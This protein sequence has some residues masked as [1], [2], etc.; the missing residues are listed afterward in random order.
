M[1]KWFTDLLGTPIMMSKTPFQIGRMLELVVDPDNGSLI[2]LVTTGRQVIAP[3]DLCPF[4]F[5]RFQVKEADV[6][7]ETDELIRLQ[8]T[9]KEKR[10]LFGKRVIT[11]S[12]EKLGRVYDLAFEMGTF[13]LVEFLVCKKIAFLWTLQKRIFSFKDILEITEKAIIVKESNGKEVVPLI[14]PATA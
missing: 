6:L 8:T 13:S 3:I 5:G 1:K 10:R 12:G 14:E 2:A 9:P 4:E 11:K 7:L